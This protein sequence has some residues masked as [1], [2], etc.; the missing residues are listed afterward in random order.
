MNQVLKILKGTK[1]MKLRLS[2]DNLEVIKWWV[3]ASYNAHIDCKRQRGAMLTLG[4]G[5][6]IS[7]SSKEK[8]NMRSSVEGELVGIDDALP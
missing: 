6:M 5:S 4:K 3:D 2:M 7:K 1:K 8:L